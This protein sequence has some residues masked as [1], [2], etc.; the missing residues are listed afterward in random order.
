MSKERVQCRSLRSLSEIRRPRNAPQTLLLRARE[1][2]HP[3]GVALNQLSVLFPS[4][5]LTAI[6][7]RTRKPCSS[8][9]KLWATACRPDLAGDERFSV[10]CKAWTRARMCHSNKDP[11][12]VSPRYALQEGICT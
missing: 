6:C 1:H 12:C 11:L 7:T 5:K 4:V 10:P 2:L 3:L 9:S 8:Y